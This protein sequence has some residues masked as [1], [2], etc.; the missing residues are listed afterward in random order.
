MQVV[1]HNTSM[2][3]REYCGEPGLL[4]LVCALPEAALSVGGAGPGQPSSNWALQQAL[5]LRTWAWPSL[6]LY[7][8]VKGGTG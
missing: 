6:T 8:F 3:G 7:F 5:H 2:T 4:M 1:A